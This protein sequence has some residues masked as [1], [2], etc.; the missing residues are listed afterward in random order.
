MSKHE[1]QVRRERRKTDRA[2]RTRARSSSSPNSTANPLVGRIPKSAAAALAA[3]AAIAAGTAAYAAPV[4]FDNPAHG[5]PGHFEWIGGTP[6]HAIALDMVF[7]AASQT[8]DW[9]SYSQF[10]QTNELDYRGLSQVYAF[11]RQN[12]EGYVQVSGPFGD[13]LTGVDSGDLIPS[14]MLWTNSGNIWY[15]G[16]GGYS[17][18]LEGE[19]TYLGVRFPIT[20]GGSDH[21]G[22]IGV[23]RT[24]QDLDAFA[25]G[26]ETTPGVPIEAGIPEPGS[27]ALLA[28]GAVAVLRKRHAS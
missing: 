9:D 5:D 25:W 10:G 24:G 4:R 28:V 12:H 13:M 22:W 15:G 19:Q 27:L 18:L 1:K 26:Y 16:A 11:G 17:Y 7:D 23:V 20:V 21:Y 8:G 6:D 2:R 14:G 3:A